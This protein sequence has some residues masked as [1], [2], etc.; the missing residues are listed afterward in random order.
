MEQLSPW[1]YVGMAG[2]ASAFLLYAASGLAAPWW[3]ALGMMLVWMGFF[4]L[5][6][7]WWDRHPVRLVLLPVAAFVL[8]PV[9]LNVGERFL[10]WN[11]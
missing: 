3:G 9:L 1:P 4:A 8:W 11:A 5:G 7:I 10:G 6:L 2:L